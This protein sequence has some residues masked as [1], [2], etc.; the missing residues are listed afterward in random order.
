MLSNGESR[1]AHWAVVI[2]R[3]RR[4]LSFQ[5]ESTEIF[6]NLVREIIESLPQ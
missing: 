6:T 4:N 5:G 1:N 2:L 3:R